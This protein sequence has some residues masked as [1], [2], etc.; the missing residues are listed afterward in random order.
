MVGLCPVE[1]EMILND[2]DDGMY[3]LHRTGT[4]EGFLE[5]STLVITRKLFNCA[6]S[7]RCTN[8]RREGRGTDRKSIR[9]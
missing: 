5:I 3:P 4:P 8:E 9:S 6:Y 2:L 1:Y 7:L